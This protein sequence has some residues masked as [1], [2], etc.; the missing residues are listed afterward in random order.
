MCQGVSVDISNVLPTC[1][2]TQRLRFN[3][4]PRS[5]THN[6]LPPPPSYP[7]WVVQYSS[8]RPSSFAIPFNGQ[9]FRQAKHAGRMWL[10]PLSLL[11]AC[12]ARV[13]TVYV[14]CLSIVVLDGTEGKPRDRWID[15][16]TRE[17]GAHYPVQEKKKG[18]RADGQTS[19]YIYLSIQENRNRKKKCWERDEETRN[20]VHKSRNRSPSDARR[21]YMTGRAGGSGG[22]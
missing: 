20:D 5:H 1:S 10:L 22:I 3:R 16:G 2:D 17:T 19:V 18:R 12:W 8:G 14:L 6:T 21:K 7:H 9:C 4:R 11:G 15:A 13:C